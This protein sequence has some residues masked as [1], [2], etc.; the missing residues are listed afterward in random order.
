MWSVTCWQSVLECAAWVLFLGGSFSFH[1]ICQA[2][3]WNC[4][5]WWQ[6][7]REIHR[8]PS[9]T[10]PCSEN[11]EQP[12][13][14]SL[15]S[16]KPLQ[17]PFGYHVGKNFCLLL[18]QDKLKLLISITE[19]PVLR[20]LFFFSASWTLW[21]CPSLCSLWRG[22]SKSGELN[23]KPE[24]SPRLFRVCIDGLCCHLLCALAVLNVK[25]LRQ[26][27]SFAVFALC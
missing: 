18:L 10:S 12:P 16:E 22:L 23:W 6:A 11:R 5:L 19:M 7:L 4:V 20:K 15:R 24:N 25:M 14:I 8:W 3:K 13:K 2:C 26:W 17:L 9:L 27:L 1:D 21:K